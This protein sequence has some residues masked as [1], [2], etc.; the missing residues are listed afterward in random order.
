MSKTKCYSTG[1]CE[2]IFTME[3][4]KLKTEFDFMLLTNEST[5]EPVYFNLM[6]R[7]SVRFVATLRLV[8]KINNKNTPLSPKGKF[9]FTTFLMTKLKHKHGEHHVFGL[10]IR[11]SDL[12]YVIMYLFKTSQSRYNC[13]SSTPLINLSFRF[14]LNLF[15]ADFF[16][17]PPTT[18]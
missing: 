9:L 6:I 13:F 10:L 14:F 5:R 16:A 18:N 15:I 3:S 8:A 7:W 11:S 12:Q 2:W 1:S 4:L 17:N